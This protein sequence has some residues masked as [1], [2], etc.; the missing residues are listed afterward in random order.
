MMRS[1]LSS[2]R[3]DHGSRLGVIYAALLGVLLQGPIACS[4][5]ERAKNPTAAP[6]DA[7]STDDGVA[8]E[9][10]TDPSVGG[11]SGTDGSA[12]SDDGSDVQVEPDAGIDVG[13]ISPD[14]SVPGLP[15]NP[16]DVDT[17]VD[18]PEESAPPICT[19]AKWTVPTSI[20]GAPGQQ[21]NRL[22]TVSADGRSWLVQTV[23]EPA[24][25]MDAAPPAETQV[26]GDV[27]G[28]DGPDG[29]SREPTDAGPFV[30]AGE[31]TTPAPKFSY[32][33]FDLP[34][35]M[36]ELHLA[37]YDLDR[38]AA[39]NRD[40]TELIAVQTVPNLLGSFTRDGLGA[41]FGQGTT[42]G[43]VPLQNIAFQTGY[44]YDTPTLTADGQQLFLSVR[45][46]QQHEIRR[47]S[48][49]DGTWDTGRALADL[50][51][52]LEHPESTSITSVSTDGR[53]LFLWDAAQGETLQA[54]LSHLG[55]ATGEVEPTGLNAPVFVND[56]CSKLW[57]LDDVGQLAVAEAD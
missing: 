30:D 27:G 6:S 21:F 16:D 29:G 51:A 42:D 33:L 44:A 5:D 26:P 25:T 45:F 28:A 53:T 50:Q 22:V 17:V 41:G 43:F 35:T 46:R 49:R 40:G 38:G 36:T 54:E 39:L 23:T 19:S 10:S 4:D 12:S 52:L 37:D 9:D 7:D 15:L 8:T 31:M 48:Q 11:P 2:Q 1:S 34:G 32:F 13:A 57:T 55:E 24:E 14:A 20:E 18:E 56:D 47:L 3:R